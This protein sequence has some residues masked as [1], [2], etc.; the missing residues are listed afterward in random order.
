MV[1][2]ERSAGN[3][4][5]EAAGEGPAA[6]GTQGGNHEKNVMAY[7]A[8]L[9]FEGCA[10]AERSR[11][12]LVCCGLQPGGN[13]Y[14]GGGIAAAASGA[15][16]V[17]V[18]QPSSIAANGGVA[19]SWLGEKPEVPSD[20]AKTIDCDLLVIGGGNSGIVAARKAAEL[21]A[22][23]VVMEKQPQDTWSPI[24]CDCGTINSQAYLDTGAEAVDEMAVFNEWQI[25]SFVRTMP[26]NAKVFAT[27]SGEAAD[28]M[29]AVLSPRRSL[30][31][32]SV[33]YSFPN[34]R[35]KTIVK[36]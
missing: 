6:L 4:S 30:D 29:C 16:G 31:E 28:F 19:P 8:S 9:V 26:Y 32:Y 22:K 34:G 20:I 24:G 1:R 33:Y 35:N 10:G 27:R 12:L 14:E 36:P 3:R 2:L 21:G 25:R 7:P 18:G 15:S 13:V 11:P 23:V 17:A 5:I